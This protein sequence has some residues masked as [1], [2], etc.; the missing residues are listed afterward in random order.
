MRSAL[1]VA[2]AALMVLGAVELKA[3]FF[4]AKDPGVRNTPPGA[5]GP[6]A[7]LTDDER[8]MFNVGRDDFAEEEDVAD[9]VGP[10]FNFV[11]CAGCHSQPAIGGTSPR[12]NPLFRVTEELGFTGNVIPS[13]IKRNGP[14]RE[15]RL[16]YK[17]D[18]SRDGGVTN[19]FVIAGHE[20][21][22]GCH[23]EQ[24]D[25]EREIR[26][27]N[28]VFRIPSPVFGTGLIE[29]I[30]DTT[31]LANLAA[32]SST[33]QS[34]GIRGRVNRNG[35]DGTITRFGWKAQNQSLLI[36]SAEA[37]NVEMGITNQGFQQEREQD[38]S[39]QFADVP[40]DVVPSVREISA[41]DN[42]A[43]FQRFLAPPTP[44]PDKPGGAS[45]IT[46]GFQRLKDVGCALCHTPTLKTPV[47]STVRALSNKN[48]NLFSDLAL[49]AMGPGL[50]DDILQGLAR[51][52]EFRTAPLWGLGQRVFF[53]HDGRTDDLLEAIREHKSDGNSR[54]G[55]SEANGVIERFNRLDEREKQ[56]LLNFLRSLY[57]PRAF[58]APLTSPRSGRGRVCSS[59]R[60][61][62]ASAILLSETL[63]T[64]RP[65]YRAA[66]RATLPLRPC[67]IPDRDR[68][69][70]R[71]PLSNAWAR[72]S[73]ARVRGD[74]ARRPASGRSSADLLEDTR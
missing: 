60:D 69:D 51:G 45:S 67:A 57:R 42:F 74:A 10:R 52:D 29:Q 32:S 2:V 27:R 68:E 38:P 48:A 6:L 15:A 34:L 24:P 19:L 11:G 58:A 62:D 26:N 16:Q 63:S 22:P 65:L 47:K 23:I 50:A 56:D 73:R 18:G 1:V 36:F 4:R 7:G 14:I 54:F 39:C 49:H 33:K 64:Y 20:D 41:I 9:G 53:L 72:A 3:D 61:P 13:F 37:Y 46:R 31:I 55:P 43:N 71:G 35:N 44:S 5:G 70:F 12:E 30:L 40:N 59:T 25:F 21:A 28:I 8:E 17:P 66:K